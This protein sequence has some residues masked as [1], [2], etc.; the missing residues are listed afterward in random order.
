MLVVLGIHC[1]LLDATAESCP[2]C[3]VT[4]YHTKHGDQ[5]C[6]PTRDFGCY[7]GESMMW[8]R[9]AAQCSG[10]FRCDTGHAAVRCGS[11]YFRPA[12]GQE[13]LNC[14][15]VDK[16][17]T[18]AIAGTETLPQPAGCGVQTGVDDMGGVSS[19]YR[20]LPQP[21]SEDRSVKCC[22]NKWTFGGPID[23]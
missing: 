14:S 5:A 12:A 2:S 3:S 21:A 9:T 15:C 7:P 6:E 10:F 8:I 22:R 20:R 23:W 13:R 19:E 1:L 4:R 18:T 11:R 17:A 16:R